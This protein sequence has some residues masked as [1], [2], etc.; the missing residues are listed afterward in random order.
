M[1]VHKQTVGITEL[2]H[3]AVMHP[4]LTDAEALRELEPQTRAFVKAH[5]FTRCPFLSNC[6]HNP[7]RGHKTA[8]KRLCKAEAIRR[9]SRGQ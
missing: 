6:W 5:N 1:T 2:E 7:R 3:V 8:C 4:R 9:A